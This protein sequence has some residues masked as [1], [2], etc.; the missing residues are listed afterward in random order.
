MTS[1]EYDLLVHVYADALRERSKHYSHR[2]LGE[3]DPR[4]MLRLASA[5]EAASS[6]LLEVAKDGPRPRIDLRS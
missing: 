6:L 3:D 1:D 2:A 5:L 4:P